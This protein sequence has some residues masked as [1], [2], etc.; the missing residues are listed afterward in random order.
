M[1]VDP[2][3]AIR[4][5][6]NA[7]GFGLQ[8]AV[9]HAVTESNTPWR[10]NSREHGWRDGDEPKFVD[11]VLSHSGGGLHLVVE[12]KRTQGGVWVLGGAAPS[13]LAI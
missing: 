9:E 11:L 10:V 1:S 7:Y 5:I 12:C 4:A 6:A 8:L 3:D 2:S 13:I